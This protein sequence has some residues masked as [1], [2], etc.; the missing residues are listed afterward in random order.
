VTLQEPSK[1][2]ATLQNKPKLLRILAIETAG[3]GCSV[4]LYIN[5]ETSFLEENAQ[6]KHTANLLPMVNKLLAK[7]GFKLNEL[8][9][10]AVDAGPGSFTGLRIGAG[11]AQGLAYAANL[12][13]INISSL[14]AMALKADAK[15]VAVALD[16]RMQEIYFAGY[17]KVKADELEV[18]YKPCL[19]KPETIEL[20]PRLSWQLVGNGWQEYKDKYQKIEISNYG[21]NFG[22]M[23]HA[24]EAARLAVINYWSRQKAEMAQ[25]VYLRSAV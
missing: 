22:I 17:K 20:D 11:V 3:P 13:V 16:A 15:Y 7:S 19:I 14:Q 6:N 1:H 2:A 25:P 21:Q 8:D 9:A 10:V 4:A 23:P 12:P 18:I 5:G 24:R